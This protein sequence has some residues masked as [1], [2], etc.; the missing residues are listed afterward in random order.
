MHDITG[1]KRDVLYVIAGLGEPK[2][3]AIH[4]ELESYYGTDINHGR[5]YQNL[6]QLV[7]MGLIE[8]G[9]KDERTNAYTLTT[10]AERLLESR[11]QWEDRYLSDRAE[12]ATS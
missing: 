7:E 4:A 1:F 3:L 8:K 10:D 6:D 2:G 9:K 5:L 12:I 11:R